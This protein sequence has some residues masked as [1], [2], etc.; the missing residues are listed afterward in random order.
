M[1]NCARKS[2]ENEKAKKEE[3]NERLVYDV[4][5]IGWFMLSAILL[6]KQSDYCIYN[7]SYR[8]H[9]T[10]L[11]ESPLSFSGRCGWKVLEEM[12]CFVFLSSYFYFVCYVRS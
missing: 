9:H 11:L 4:W 7:V 8:T 10:S 1:R 3:K 5:E 2:R 6:I 12:F